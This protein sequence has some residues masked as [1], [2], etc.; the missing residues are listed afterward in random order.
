MTTL[1]GISHF[2]N[3]HAAPAGGHQTEPAPDPQTRR[4]FGR[5]EFRNWN[6]PVQKPR[7]YRGPR[8]P[9]DKVSAS[10]PDGYRFETRVH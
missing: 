8:W 6:P 5:A 3:F 1:S 4:I 2:P 9:S 7:P 10:A